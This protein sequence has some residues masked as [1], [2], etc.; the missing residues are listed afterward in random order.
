MRKIK[1]QNIKKKQKAGFFSLE[2]VM[3]ISI[4]VV[5]AIGLYVYNLPENVRKVMNNS[6]ASMNDVLNANQDGGYNSSDGG[7]HGDFSDATGST[8]YPTEANWNSVEDF[9]Y[10]ETASGVTITGYTGTSTDV[11][12]PSE[13]DNLPVIKVAGSAFLA[14]G[15][16][17]V[18]VP[19]SVT[20][21][22]PSAFKNNKLEN[23]VAPSALTVIG[24]EA[25]ANNQLYAVSFNIRLERIGAGGFRNNQ[26]SYVNTKKIVTL[27]ANSFF[28]NEIAQIKI[29]TSLVNLGQGSFLE[30]GGLNGKAGIV[31][32]EGEESRFNEIWSASFDDKFFG[33]K[34]A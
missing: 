34:P 27:G 11:V 20:E 12:I 33:S 2:Y 25:F 14:K 32:I 1:K 18:R 16:T 26:I 3:L 29:G 22:G 24:E 17:S 23:F 15:L 8:I 28:Q 4:I 30:Q 7:Y 10:T 31:E 13:I 19:N 5:F 9:V 6:G 21:I